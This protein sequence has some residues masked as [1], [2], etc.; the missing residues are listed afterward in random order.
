M[1]TPYTPT[2]PNDRIQQIDILR[3]FALFGVLVVNVFGYNSSFFDFSGF[4]SGFTEELNQKVFSFVVN[5]GADKFIGL[6]SILFGISF[7]II[8]LKH[9]QNEQQFLRFYSRRLW[10]L[11]F[12][13]I[14]HIL[15]FWAGDILLSYSLLGFVLLFSR[16]R[17]SKILFVS[18]VFIYFF[19]ILYIALTVVFPF[20]PDA[21]SSTS[22]IKMPEVVK[23]YSNGSIADIFR[24]RLHE[25]WSFRNINTFYYAPKVLSLFIFGYLFHKHHFI[26]KIN[27]QKSKYSIISVS[28]LFC[29]ILLNTYTLEIVNLLAHRETNAFFTTWYMA[30]F[31]ITNVLL[32]ISYLLLILLLSN[33]RFLKYFLIPLK[34]VGRMSLTNYLLYS[35]VFTTLMYAYGFGKFGSFEPWE[36]VLIAFVVFCFQ[37]ILCKLWLQQFQFG[38]MEWI[39][40]RLSYR[41]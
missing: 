17:S 37:I 2:P 24:L 25:Y 26:E 6:F 34:Y 1:K 18:S 36:L 16:K 11:M 4:Y 10:A 14:L 21:L 19:P 40:R 8:Y 23:I 12:F 35:L 32:I 39:W 27:T 33:H 31:E 41:K 38:P 9:K 13:G 15:F 29:G 20:F 3:G 5:Y 22:Q 28:L 30:I 7:S